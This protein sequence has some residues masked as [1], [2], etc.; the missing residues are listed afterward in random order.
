MTEFLKFPLNKGGQGKGAG[1]ILISAAKP[2]GQPLAPLLR[3]I[4][5][6]VLPL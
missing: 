4:C 1:V 2:D 6:P 3:G 5:C